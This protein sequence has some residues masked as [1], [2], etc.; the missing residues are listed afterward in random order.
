MRRLI[1]FPAWFVL[2]LIWTGI[3]AYL[4]Y[5]TL[6]YVPMDMS[7]SDPATQDAFRATMTRHLI[8]YGLLAAGPPAIALVFGSLLCRRA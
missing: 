7:P 1:S 5:T 4:A 6:P 8:L 2:S 3:V